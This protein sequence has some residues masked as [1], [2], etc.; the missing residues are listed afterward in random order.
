MGCPSARARAR[1]LRRAHDEAALRAAPSEEAAL[2]PPRLRRKGEGESDEPSQDHLSAKKGGAPVCG[3]A[4]S[5]SCEATEHHAH[6]NAELHPQ[7][8]LSLGSPRRLG[9]GSV[10]AGGDGQG[11]CPA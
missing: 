6:S 5:A 10:V 7:G 2:E 4:M 9:R 8:K 3:W 1:A 11:G